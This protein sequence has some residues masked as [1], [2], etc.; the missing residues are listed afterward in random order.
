V[1][2]WG[3]MKAET[4]LTPCI[5]QL[6]MYYK[7]IRGN[8]FNRPLTPCIEQLPMHYK[9]NRGNLSVIKIIICGNFAFND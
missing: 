5:E 2:A 3:E 1:L 8:I 4:P 7:K 9:K 6:P